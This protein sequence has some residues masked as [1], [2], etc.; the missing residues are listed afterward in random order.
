MHSRNWQNWQL[1]NLEFSNRTAQRYMTIHK[2]AAAL[3]EAEITTLSKAYRFVAGPEREKRL[4]RDAAKAELGV[5]LFQWSTRLNSLLGQLQGLEK[6]APTDAPPSVREELNRAVLQLN[7]AK[8]ALT[9][10]S[11]PTPK[12]DTVTVLPEAVARE[13]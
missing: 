13:A 9:I 1:V 3:R 8:S 12:S 11:V 7:A 6:S 10:R 5:E 2:K 4:E